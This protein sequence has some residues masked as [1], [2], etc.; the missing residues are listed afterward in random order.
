MKNFK[1]L[2]PFF[3]ISAVFVAVTVYNLIGHIKSNK[4]IITIGDYPFC[5]MATDNYTIT[6]AKNGFR[7]QGGKNKGHFEIL[8][9]GLNPDFSKKDLG[10]FEAVYAKRKNFRIV[11]YKIDENTIL[12]DTFEAIIH[13][14]P[15]LTPSKGTG[16]CTTLKKLHPQHLSL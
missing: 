16:F 8:K 9:R 3:L 14:P 6:P 10:G 11:E 5:V 2:F 1:I 13:L 15:N 4:V 7:Y 12:R